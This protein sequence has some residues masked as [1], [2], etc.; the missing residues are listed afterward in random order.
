MFNDNDIHKR[1]MLH[2][3]GYHWF[4]FIGYHWFNS[5]LCVEYNS[6]ICPAFVFFV[7]CLNTLLPWLFLGICPHS[8][9]NGFVLFMNLF[10]KS[11]TEFI[12]SFF[13]SFVLSLSLC[14]FHLIIWFPAFNHTSTKTPLEWWNS[15]W[16]K[17]KITLN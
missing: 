4:N 15:V 11:Q 16:R 13:L 3:I 17:I 9:F 5:L 7:V 6:F 10:F 12:A 8:Q 14:I 2:F 1:K